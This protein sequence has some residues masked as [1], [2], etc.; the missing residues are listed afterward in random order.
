MA[1]KYNKYGAGHKNGNKITLKDINPY[2]RASVNGMGHQ[3]CFDK[4]RTFISAKIDGQGMNLW[5]D[6]QELNKIIEKLLLVD[7]DI[8]KMAFFGMIQKGKAL[9][10]EQFYALGMAI[11]GRLLDNKNSVRLEVDTKE[12]KIYYA[13]MEQT[14]ENIYEYE[15]YQRETYKTTRV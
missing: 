11:C 14:L 13:E 8:L 12:M 6:P 9:L 5:V 10:N 1:Q 4:G 3:E 2:S 15:N 7:E